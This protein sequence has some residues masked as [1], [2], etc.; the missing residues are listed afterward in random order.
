MRDVAKLADVS[1]MTVSRVLKG[2]VFVGEEARTRVLEAVAKLEYLP[3]EIAR[4]LREQRTRQIGI[5]VPNLHDP[6]FA[7]CANSISLV[8]KQHAYST[9][10]T[11]SDEDPATEL[12]EAKRMLRRHIEGLIIIPSPGKSLATDPEFRNTPIVTLDRPISGSSFDRVVVENKHGAQQ[13]VQH[14]ID[15]GH[16]RIACLSL[17][18][19]LWTMQQRLAGY[20]AAIQAANL[21]P[22]SHVVPESPESVLQTLRTLLARKSPPTAI[23][24]CNNLITRNLLHAFATL[25]IRVPDQIAFLGFDD[26]E[27]ADLLNPPI[28]VIRQPIDIMGRVGAE[29]LFSKLTASTPEA[30]PKQIILPTEL[31]IRH[32][33]GPHNPTDI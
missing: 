10:I 31:V 27:T 17:S 9:I 6:F 22:D 2:T 15:H 13:G 18:L 8:A 25:N 1:T 4:S 12:L 30:K 3:N 28:S 14:L 21:K 26:F 5:I 33:C 20:R 19:D 11:T 23:F 16:R 7:T 24:S 29:L 32:S